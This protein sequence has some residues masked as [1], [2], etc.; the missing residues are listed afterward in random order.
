[1]EK[2]SIKPNEDG[3]VIVRLYGQ[4]FDLTDEVKNGEA[5]LHAFGKDYLISV[6]GKKTE[7]KEVAKTEEQVAEEAPVENSEEA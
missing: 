3:K 2:I 7:Q 6:K 1:M 5:Q 4:D